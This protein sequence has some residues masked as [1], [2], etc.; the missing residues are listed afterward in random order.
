MREGSSIGPKFILWHNG[1]WW[2]WS[3]LSYF[4]VWSVRSSWSSLA[5]K[6]F[7]RIDVKN[8]QFLYNLNSHLSFC[9]RRFFIKSF[10]TVAIKCV[11][12]WFFIWFILVLPS[13]SLGECLYLV[14]TL[15]KRK[16]KCF[17]NNNAILFVLTCITAKINEQQIYHCELSAMI[18]WLIVLCL[19]CLYIYYVVPRKR[20]GPS[21]DWNKCSVSVTWSRDEKKMLNYRW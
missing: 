12:V 6:D 15:P 14:K 16:V 1:W 18:N 8:W 4:M 10:F 5:D 19:Y 17:H 20:V 9:T 7:S 11:W 21:R 13:L 2:W 3:V